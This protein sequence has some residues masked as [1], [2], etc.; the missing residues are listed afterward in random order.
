M[1]SVHLDINDGST[2]LLDFNNKTLL[3]TF[4]SFF[5]FTAVTPVY[6]IWICWTTPVPFM[7]ELSNFDDY[8]DSFLTTVWTLVF[9]VYVKRCMTVE[10]R[11]LHWQFL[12]DFWTLVFILMLKD[13][14][15]LND[16]HYI[17]S[18]KQFLNA[19]VHFDVKRWMTVERRSLHW[20]F[21]N[22]CLI[23]SVHFLC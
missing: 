16:V 4:E 21:L 9:I 18:F 3:I 7:C 22:D 11:S 23:A 6:F 8:I 5:F 2:M 15:L 17:D 14:W 1:Y 19:S 10:R 12:N 20:Q 13:E